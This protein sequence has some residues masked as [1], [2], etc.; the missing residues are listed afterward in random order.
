MTHW[1]G[2]F[3]TAAL[4]FFITFV[5][6][7]LILWYLRFYCDEQTKYVVI[8]KIIT[9]AITNSAEHWADFVASYIYNEKDINHD[10]DD[11]A[12]GKGY[13]VSNPLVVIVYQLGYI[14]GSPIIGKMKHNLLFC[15]L[16]TNDESSG[17]G[18]IVA[19]FKVSMTRDFGWFKQQNQ[20]GDQNKKITW[21]TDIQQVNPESA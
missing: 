13:N 8:G 6:I 20:M 9:L 14:L 4:S 11:T 16:H 21:V 18:E 7:P 19:G 5:D 12:T 10:A 1:H 17:L 3:N 2:D 15:D